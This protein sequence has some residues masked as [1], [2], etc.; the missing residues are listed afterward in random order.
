MLYKTIK[1]ILVNDLGY[2]VYDT[3]LN[4]ADYGIP[5]TRN[6]TYIVC[7]SNSK[8]LFAFPEKQPLTLKLQD[9]LE[10]HSAVVHSD[11]D[12]GVPVLLLLAVDRHLLYESVLPCRLEGNLVLAAE[13]FGY[14]ENDCTRQNTHYALLRI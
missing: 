14:S 10:D 11:D 4:T 7:F 1:N 8:A 12:H 2:K 13:H 3:V 9:L 5:Q 6:R